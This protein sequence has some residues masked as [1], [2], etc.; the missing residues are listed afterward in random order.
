MS[1]PVR[2]VTPGLRAA[3]DR[4]I[5]EWGRMSSS[6]GINRTMAQ[7]HALLVLSADPY[8]VE[9][10]IERLHISRGNASMNLR[11]LLDWG[12]IERDR[13]PGD[14][15]DIYGAGGDVLHMFARVIRERKRREI[16]PTVHA[17]RECL[18]MVP[19]DDTSDDAVLLRTRLTDLLDVFE[20][21]DRVF[22]EVFRTDET[23]RQ[24]ID[25]VRSSGAWT[26]TRQGG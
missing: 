26:A 14:R 4:F 22:D 18:N 9:E 8:T 5:Q 12:I 24:T 25:L 3:Q 2:T 10:L 19:E 16:D 1:E 20:L 17:I 21:F 11:D 15:K 23:F 6:W 7:I 13:M